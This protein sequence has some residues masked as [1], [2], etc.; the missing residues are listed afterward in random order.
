[1]NWQPLKDV[2]K[3]ATDAFKNH[4]VIWL[5][6]VMALFCWGFVYLLTTHK[7]DTVLNST[8]MVFGGVASIIVTGIIASKSY[9]K[10]NAPAPEDPD[11]GEDPGANE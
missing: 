9:E 6:V 11:T 2:V 7:S 4:M 3:E 5:W 10:V 8:Y 1:M